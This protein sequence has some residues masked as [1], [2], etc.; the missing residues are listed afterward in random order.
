MVDNCQKGLDTNSQSG[1]EMAELGLVISQPSATLLL[2]Y[3]SPACVAG[4]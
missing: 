4:L 2:G 1:V 3:Y